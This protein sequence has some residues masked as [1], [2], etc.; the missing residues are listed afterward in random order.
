MCLWLVIE[1]SQYQ[2]AEICL[3]PVFMKRTFVLYKNPFDR[4][5][6]VLRDKVI[7]YRHILGV[8]QRGLIVFE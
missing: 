3:T 7:V 6:S 8:I 5:A 1:K 2:I 4:R